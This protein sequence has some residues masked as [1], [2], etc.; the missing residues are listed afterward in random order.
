MLPEHLI[1]RILYEA[2]LNI[3]T[4]LALKM[5]PRRMNTDMLEFLIIFRS[6]QIY[7]SNKQ[8][9]HSIVY[10]GYHVIRRPITLDYWGE[11]I[12]I[13]NAAQSEYSLDITSPDGVNVVFPGNVNLVYIVQK[14]KVA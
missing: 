11:G 13:F 8:T 14:L 2:D 4:R 10:P 7:N 5:K 12:S 6:G 1:E 9:L 3:D